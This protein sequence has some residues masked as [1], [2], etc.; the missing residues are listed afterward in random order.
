MIRRRILV[1]AAM[2]GGI[3]GTGQAQSPAAPATIRP[4]AASVDMNEIVCQKLKETG[5]R[6]AVRKVCRTRAEW[7]DLK[8]QDRQSLEQAQTQIGIMK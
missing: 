2:I 4:A 1:I 6:I 8:L 3:A 5:S 7:A